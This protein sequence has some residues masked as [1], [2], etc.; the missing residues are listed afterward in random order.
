[1]REARARHNEGRLALKKRD[2]EQEHVFT[3]SLTYYDILKPS[4][5]NA[6]VRYEDRVAQRKEE[7]TSLQNALNS[8]S[9]ADIA[10][11]S[12]SSLR[13]WRKPTPCRK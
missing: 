8:L 9:G 3:A 2:L 5:V 6:A 11:A 7:L 12:S 1:M 13:A 4:C 10:Y